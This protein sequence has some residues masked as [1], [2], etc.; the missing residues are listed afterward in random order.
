MCA[1]TF[2]AFAKGITACLSLRNNVE[3][4][5]AN[6]R[7]SSAKKDRVDRFQMTQSTFVPYS[8]ITYFGTFTQLTQ[9]KQPFQPTLILN[10]KYLENI[11]TPQNK[12]LCS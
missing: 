9:M 11:L 6:C 5:G 3:E 4:E 8:W 2:A 7:T 10:A 12:G 1:Q